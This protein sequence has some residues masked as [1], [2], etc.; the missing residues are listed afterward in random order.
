[1]LGAVSAAG[2]SSR[3]LEFEGIVAGSGAGKL[4]LVAGEVLID[5]GLTRGSAGALATLAAEQDQIAGAD[6]GLIPLLAALLVVP[7]MRAQAAFDVYGAAFLEV[8]AGDLR[9]ARPAGDVV[10][11]GAVLPVAILVFEAVVGCQREV[12][13]GGAAV[14]VFQ[15]RGPAQMP[16]QCHA[17]QAFCHDAKCPCCRPSGGWFDGGVGGSPRSGE[18]MAAPEAR[19]GKV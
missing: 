9:Q 17:I 3:P 11:L 16:N 14:G 8:L 4:G 12:G 6:V 7:A 15:L 10:P 2:R 19:S 18:R 13:H 1:M 5:L